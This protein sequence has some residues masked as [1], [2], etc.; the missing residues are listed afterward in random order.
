MVAADGASRKGCAKAAASSGTP[1][2]KTH[3]GGRRCQQGGCTKAAA[4]GGTRHLRTATV[5]SRH[6][7]LQNSLALAPDALVIPPSMSNVLAPTCDAACEPSVCEIALRGAS[8]QKHITP[9]IIPP[10]R[11]SAYHAAYRH[12]SHCGFGG[13]GEGGLVKRR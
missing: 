2:C 8:T 9:H 11:L 1:H 6:T 5:T 12:V 3:G 7:G 10:V 13:N 4:D